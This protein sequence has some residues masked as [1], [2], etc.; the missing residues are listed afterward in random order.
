[1]DLIVHLHDAEHMIGCGLIYFALFMPRCLLHVKLFV[2]RCLYQIVSNC[3][4]E[5]CKFFWHKF[6]LKKFIL[7][8]DS[9]GCCSFCS[10]AFFL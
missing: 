9:I 6:K 10:S 7:Y 3:L 1:M 4:C 2:Q 8:S 5:D